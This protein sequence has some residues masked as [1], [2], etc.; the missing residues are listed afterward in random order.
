MPKNE[1]SVKNSSSF[2][3]ELL[4]NNFQADNLYITSY[5]VEN[6]YTNVPLRETI[7]IIVNKIFINADSSFIG[8]SKS[9][10]TKLLEIATTNC[11]FLFNGQLYKQCDGLGMG[12]PQSPIFADIFLSFHE[13]M[14]LSNCPIEFK[15]I[16]YR[17]YVDD[18]FILFSNKSHTP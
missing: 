2:V 8:L 16:F 4:S 13:D 7:N 1:Y 10:F 5:D 15:P 12:L 3:S 17:L 18:T 9:C 14:W 11:F 6:L